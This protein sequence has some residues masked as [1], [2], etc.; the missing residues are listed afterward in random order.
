MLQCNYPGQRDFIPS[1]SNPKEQL[2]DKDI[3]PLREALRTA[4][5]QVSVL[6]EFIQTHKHGVFATAGTIYTTHV[7]RWLPIIGEKDLYAVFEQLETKSGLDIVCFLFSVACLC[8]TEI[9]LSPDL[10]EVLATAVR[11][12]YSQARLEQYSVTLVQA[13]LLLAT[14]EYG[15][16]AMDI[17]YSVIDGCRSMAQ[18]LGIIT[19]ELSAA[20]L[21]V[22]MPTLSWII[23]LLERLILF[24]CNSPAVFMIEK[25]VG[26][27][28][29]PIW[30][31][32]DYANDVIE[33]RCPSNFESIRLL[34][35]VLF[36]I[37]SA[38]P[39]R[40]ETLASLDLELVRFLAMVYEEDAKVPG[41]RCQSILIGS[42]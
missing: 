33:S 41:R 29:E 23:L 21:Q 17:A 1:H 6:L 4:D 26:W 13:G 25:H 27:A 38:S 3:R 15:Q 34:D 28:L 12:L 20:D 37:H 5:H 36:V 31:T 32:Q 11:I 42:L 7:Y 35:R 39:T 22:G 10:R 16:G 24:E 30:P 19:E 8:L 18:L 2:W 9:H 14:Y 40:D